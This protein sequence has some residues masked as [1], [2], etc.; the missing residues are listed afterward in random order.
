MI[1]MNSQCSG[2]PTLFFE[3]LEKSLAFFKKDERV[4]SNIQPAVIIAANS[5]KVHFIKRLPNVLNQ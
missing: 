5:R 3:E 2:I 1:F 4:Q